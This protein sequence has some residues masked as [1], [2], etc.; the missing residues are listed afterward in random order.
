MSMFNILPVLAAVISKDDIKDTIPTV[1]ANQVTVDAALT[2]VLGIAGIVAV[3]FIIIGGM[4]Y[5]LSQGNATDL[6][7]G[8]D[9]IV[10]AL[11]GLFFVMFAFVVV[12]FATA[13]LF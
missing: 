6:Q 7:K 12:Q 10:Y 4:R 9:I 11:V 5:A 1:E 13:N 3:I 8:K 2:L